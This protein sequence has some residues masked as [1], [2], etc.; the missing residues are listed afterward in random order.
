MKAMV[1]RL[2]SQRMVRDRRWKYVWNLTAEDELYD[3]A[4]DPAELRNLATDPASAGE[5]AR[6]RG[7]MVAW[8]EATHDRILNKW[9]RRQ[10]D[11]GLKV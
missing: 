5:L 8:L 6:L 9:T 3:L 7:R 4:A 11:E 2:Y 10:L 1:D